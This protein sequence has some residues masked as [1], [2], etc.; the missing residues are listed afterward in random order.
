VDATQLFKAGQLQAALDAQLQAV[1]AA[2]AD[3]GKRLFL[4]EL[5]VFAGDLDRAR[6][7]IDALSYDDPELERARVTYLALLDAE[8]AR[9][10]LFRDGAQPGFLDTPPE[11]IAY[12]LDA[13][14]L[15]RDGRQSEAAALLD[16]ANL[17]AP[18]VSGTLNGKPFDGLRD[19]DDLFGPV[20]EV[21]AQGKY[22]WLS[23]EQVDAAALIPPKVPRDLIWAPAKL[24]SRAGEEGDVFLPALYPGSHEHPDDAVK[25]GR[26]TDWTA[27]APVRG[28][29]ARTFLAGD[30][31]VGLLELRE[32]HLP[33]SPP[34]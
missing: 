32:L 31:G 21:F 19:A 29:G 34:P 27:D 16:K 26:S 8:D 28:R 6:R 1:K 13:L 7:Q 22:L 15:I 5:A 24:V 25:L 2:P 3:H 18:P 9:R 20:L 30:D 12:R 4:F 23:V 14:K 10:K 17:M 11:H 33:D